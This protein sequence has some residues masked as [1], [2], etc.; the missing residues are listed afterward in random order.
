MGESPNTSGSADTSGSSGVDPTT[1]DDCTPDDPLPSAAVL[2]THG[3]VQGVTADGVTRF[4]G[5]PYAAAPI[6]A[7]RWQPPQSPACWS[8]VRAADVAAP[9]CPQLTSATGPITGDEDC[10]TLSVWTPDATR[11]AA[12]AVM[13]FIHGGG[14]TTGS[15]SDP[16]Y[17]GARLAAAHDVVVVT[18]EYRLGAF[19]YLAHA[20]LD[21]EDPRGV[22]GNYGL[23][24]Q[25]FALQWVAA[26]IAA[27]GGDPGN[28]T[29]FGESAGAVS[30][31]ALLGVPEVEGLVHRAI[32]QSGTCEQ[33]SSTMYRDQVGDPWVAASPCAGEA[34]VA[35]CLRALSVE[36][37]LTTEP[38]GFPSVAALG[39]VWS[40]YVDGITLPASTLDAMASGDDVDVPLIVGANAEETA[41]D[42]PPL[43][44]A[45]FEALVDATFGP[46]A[47]QVK[48]AYPL[49]DY[50]SPTAAYVALSSDVKF[51]CGARRAARAAIAGA[52]AYRY[53]FS[54][55]GYTVGPNMDASAFHGLELLYVFG[56]YDTIMLGPIAY[57]PN[58]DDEAMAAWLGEAWTTFAKTGDPSTATLAWP[59]YSSGDDPYAALDLPPTSA[60][61][62]RT[63]QCD[64]WD[65]LLGG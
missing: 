19:G 12:R 54:Y 62:V 58:A 28:V 21:D 35:A 34:D 15:G 24:D 14:H 43:D 65:A 11:D 10:L 22:S 1:S 41:R 63:E 52:P 2:T 6:D 25:L 5:I 56:N 39:Q 48:D 59:S 4:L 53:H 51:I 38:T 27:F 46:L 26:N 29:L 18:V 33:R 40:P 42:V 57:T 47:M 31:C 9:S 8:E 50:A 16:L 60:A 44:E 55:D 37:V 32:V 17:D 61:G 45:S 30:T 64:F 7:L 49:A 23:L 36:A 13:V 20:S 3:A